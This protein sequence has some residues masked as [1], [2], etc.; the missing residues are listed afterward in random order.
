MNAR[1]LADHKSIAAT[2]VST[3][4]R[5]PIHLHPDPPL[6]DLGNLCAA[7]DE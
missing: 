3:G 5:T 6:T 4:E 2:L 7:G 1:T